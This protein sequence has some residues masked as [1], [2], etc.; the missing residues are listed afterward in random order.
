MFILRI[1]QEDR[2]DASSPFEQ[3]IDNFELGSSYAVL[4]KGH[5]AEFDKIMKS[6]Y[7]G[8]SL[9]GIE[10]IVCGQNDVKFLIEKNTTLRERSYFIMTDSGET[11]E[12]I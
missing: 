5:T 2:Q 3:V 9:D 11:F 12:K 8:A 1:I 6:E 7:P 4:K 10:G